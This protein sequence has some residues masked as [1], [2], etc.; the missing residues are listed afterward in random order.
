MHK[1][2]KGSISVEASLVLPLLIIFFMQLYSAFEM[3]ALYCR[4][5]VALEETAE[6]AATFLYV[7]KGDQMSSA[8][9]FLLTETFIREELTRKIGSKNLSASVLSGKAMGLSLLRSSVAEDGNTVDLIVTYRAKPWYSLGTV[10]TVRLV[11][12]CK[13]T[14]WNGYEKSEEPDSKEEET[15]YVT[16][17]GSV[18][19]LYRDCTYLDAT[20]EVVLRDEVGEQRNQDRKKYYPCEIC[21]E[22]AEGEFY[23]ITPYGTKYHEKEDCKSLHKSVT[24]IPL[25]EAGGRKVCSKC[26]MR[27]Q[28]E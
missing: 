27:N 13:M 20:V 19:H 18:Y 1:L 28:N 5:E 25:S 9:S 2:K 3:L 4:V 24:A 22:G 26:S 8:Q 10:G 11:N 12:H 6:E 21:T 14:A 17:G 16:P 7:K 15:V 23:Y